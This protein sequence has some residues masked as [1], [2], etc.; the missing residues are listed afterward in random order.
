MVEGMQFDRGYISPYFVTDPERMVRA[1]IAGLE[2]RLSMESGHGPS[3]GV[4][5]SC[6]TCEPDLPSAGVQP[7]ARWRACMFYASPLASRHSR[8]TFVTRPHV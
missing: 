8:S 6:P 2:Q 3:D 4:A 5:D 1:L 7:V